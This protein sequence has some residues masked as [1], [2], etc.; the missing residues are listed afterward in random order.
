MSMLEEN[1]INRLSIRGEILP[2]I[3]PP[4]QTWKA[5]Y[6]PPR[7]SY[8]CKITYK[9]RKFSSKG[10]ILVL[11]WLV[12]V[13]P[14]LGTSQTE[15][16][17]LSCQRENAF[18]YINYVVPVVAWLLTAIVSG[19][20]ADTKLGNYKTIKL[21][22]TVLF[23]ATVVD[24]ITV[25]IKVSYYTNK[26]QEGWFLVIETIPRCFKFIGNA[27]FIVT[28][29]QLGLDQ[30]PDASSEN[31]TSFIAWFVFSAQ[32]GIFLHQIEAIIIGCFAEDYGQHIRPILRFLPVVYMSIA[33]CSDFFLSPKWIIKEPASSRCFKLMC[34]VLKFAW[35]HKSPLNRS[36]L[37]Y[38]EEDIPSRLDLGKS[39]YGGPFTTEQVENVKTILKILVVSIPLPVILLSYY[40][41]YNLQYF[42]KINNMTYTTNNLNLTQCVRTSL[43][44]T[45]ISVPWWML[46]ITLVHEIV[47]YPLLMKWIPTSLKRIVLGSVLTWI[48][49]GTYL[50]I[51]I[52]ILVFK[53]KES[54]VRIDILWIELIKSILLAQV[55]LLL[56]KATLE[57]VCAQTP[58]NL[59]G[60]AIGYIWCIHLLANTIS[61]AVHLILEAECKQYCPAILG[62]IG[63]VL[64]MIGLPLICILAYKY[65]TRVRDADET[66]TDYAWA[67][68]VYSKLLA[69]S[70]SQSF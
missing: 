64:S 68:K 40:S 11:F 62:S 37:T 17:E 4:R 5:T 35:K 46:L 32:A 20:I 7:Q 53:P 49:N 22:L 43:K 30:M 29:I 21:G 67:D 51:S 2:P 47:F 52:G 38:W 55:A 50:I 56:Y 60:F 61:T 41:I 26:S 66:H 12:L 42:A 23:V 9:P 34:Q 25:L 31:I 54:I 28:S 33:L 27:M 14:G 63:T 57:F 69:S 39:R 58:H 36:A 1:P 15:K 18:Q 65:K 48:Y 3:Q 6:K 44:H 13:N 16:G 45:V 24:C 8:N 59:K 10:A 19:W 70:F